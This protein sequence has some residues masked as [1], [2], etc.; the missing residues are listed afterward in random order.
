VLGLHIGSGSK[1]ADVSAWS[2]HAAG[3]TV[4]FAVALVSL[5]DWLTSGKPHVLP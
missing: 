3:T 1:L 4:T 5:V 2:P